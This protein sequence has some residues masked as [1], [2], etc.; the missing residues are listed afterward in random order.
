MRSRIA[1]GV[2]LFAALLVG[3]S[4]PPPQKAE[5]VNVTVTVTLPN[6]QP[7]KDLNLL[8]LP[9]T[10]DQLQGGGKTGANGKVQ[11]KLTPGK[12]T[13]A[14]DNAPAE[15]P[16]KYHNNDAANTVEVTTATQDLALKLT[17]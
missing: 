2:G 10:S 15:V 6:G 3:C 4:S 7:G 11:T 12:Y 5:P 13:F 8:L 1:T 14:F 16:K 9:A 17:N